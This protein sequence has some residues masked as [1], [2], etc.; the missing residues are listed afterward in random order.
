[1]VMPPPPTPP[2]FY[3][4]FA[5]LT[6]HRILHSKHAQSFQN[7]HKMKNTVHSRFVFIIAYYQATLFINWNEFMRK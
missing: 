6:V 7:L 4:S 2:T 5:V 1:V 3:L